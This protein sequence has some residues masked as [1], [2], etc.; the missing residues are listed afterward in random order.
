MKLRYLFSAILASLLLIVGCEPAET[1]LSFENI[2]LSK[3]Y[4]SIPEEGGS[5]EL[6]INATEEWV[7]DTTYTQDVWPNVISRDK[8]DKTVIKSCE[9]S[10]LSVDKMSYGAGETTVK[11]TAEAVS[12]GRELEL[13]IKAGNS[14]QFVRVR[15]GSMSVTEATCAEVI[16]GPEG[17]LYRVTGICT[18]IANTTYGNWYLNDGTGEI[19]IYGTKNSAGSYAWSDFNIEVGDEVT[20]EGAYV[21]YNGTTPEFVDATF[22]SV[23]KSLVKVVTESQTYPKEGGEFE[24]RVAYKGAGVFPTVPEEYRSW[25]SVVDMQNIPGEATK[26]EPNPADTAVVKLAIQPN[27][28]A[29]RAGSVTFVSSSSSVPY[30]FTQDGAVLEIESGFYYMISGNVAAAPVAA[31]KSYGYLGTGEAADNTTSSA[32]AFIFTAVEGG[33]T[34]QDLSGRYYYMKGTYNNFNV[35]TELPESGHVWT[36]YAADDDLVMIL[37]NTTNKY[38]QYSESY[39]SWG[40]YDSENGALPALFE[41]VAPVVADGKYYIQV[42]AGVVTPLEKTYGYLNVAE[43]A[44]ANAFTFTFTEGK[45]YTICDADGMYYYQTGTYNSFNVSDNPS[46]GQYW[47]L[48]PQTDGTMKILNLSVKKFWQYDANYSSFGSYSDLR[49]VLPELVAFE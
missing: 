13:K 5:V 11:F 4:L 15:Q 47:S 32:N 35:S 24:V 8:D 9:P 31:D 44:E 43:K 45:G 30:E 29:Y 3:T 37:N 22:I 27:N 10:W 25:V 1:N 21:L 49:G 2:K 12:G 36:I 18:A 28:A 34:I 19:Y 7:I 16:A 42:E 20:V 48:I 38:I 26:I 46:E 40:A 33:Y 6:T 41:A 39:T 23:E 14:T 17:K